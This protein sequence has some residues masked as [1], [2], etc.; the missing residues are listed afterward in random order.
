MFK[1][2]AVISLLFLV[3]ACDQ[4]ETTKRHT[5][6]FQNVI[7]ENT[8]Y[9]QDEKTGLCFAKLSAYLDAIAN[10]PCTPEVLELIRL[11]NIDE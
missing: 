4:E 8:I 7:N 2:L 6:A 10:V 5:N 3:A 1:K 9:A 11:G